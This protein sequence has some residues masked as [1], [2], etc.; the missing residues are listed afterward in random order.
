MLLWVFKAMPAVTAYFQS[1]LGLIYVTATVRAV[2]FN[3]VAWL[4]FAAF[5]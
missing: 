1:Q 4:K 2:N 5:H 3:G